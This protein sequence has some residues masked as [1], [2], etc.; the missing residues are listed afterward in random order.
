MDNE[1]KLGDGVASELKNEFNSELS[2]AGKKLIQ[3]IFRYL[4]DKVQNAD[5]DD[6][7]KKISKKD[8]ERILSLWSSQLAEEGLLPSGY[9]GLTDDLLIENL[10][11]DGYLEGLYSGYVLAML[12]LID[13][14]APREL[15]E[16]T[17]NDLLSKQ[18]GLRY[19]D[20]S[21]LFARL[22]DEKYS[23][24]EGP[25]SKN[26]YSKAHSASTQTSE[27]FDGRSS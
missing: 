4:C 23:W 8:E 21:K 14:N 10:H 26:S 17:R 3:T 20:R 1:V 5:F 24:I 22:E 19:D 16:S 11:Q 13:N 6:L 2:A 15:I 27:G 18:V 12:S 7:L 9:K 25:V